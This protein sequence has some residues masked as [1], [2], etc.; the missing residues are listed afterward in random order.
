V[1]AYVPFPGVDRLEKPHRLAI[2]P[3]SLQLIQQ[4]L[5]MPEGYQEELPETKVGEIL[6]EVSLHVTVEFSPEDSS[7]RRYSTEIRRV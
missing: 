1:A 7:F 2:L 5:Q 6:P 4:T 3:V